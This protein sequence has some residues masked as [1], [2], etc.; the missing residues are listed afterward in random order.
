[1]RV[2]NNQVLPLPAEAETVALSAG[3]QASRLLS[4]L[5]WAGMK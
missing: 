4:L 3:L 5:L 2:I 1:M